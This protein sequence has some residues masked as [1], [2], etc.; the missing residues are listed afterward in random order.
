MKSI[1]SIA[2]ALWSVLLMT[3]AAFADENRSVDM[4]NLKGGLAIQGYD[5][6]SYFP[7]GGGSPQK[8]SEAMSVTYNK[9]TYYFV[10]EANRSLFLSNPNKYEPTYGGWC[11]YAMAF[12]AFQEII[13]TLFTI[14]NNRL[15][16]FLSSRTK[17][18]FDLNLNK[19]EADADRNWKGKTG[20]EPRL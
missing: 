6:I 15:H 12:D 14:N 11:A 8:G 18:N 3:T 13:P 2:I 9:V 5:P 17:R 16:L 7:E 10:S 4:Y 1:K 20:E 19:L